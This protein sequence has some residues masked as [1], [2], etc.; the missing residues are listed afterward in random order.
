MGRLAVGENVCT[1]GACRRKC[2]VEEG[3][4]CSGGTYQE[5]DYVRRTDEDQDAT[6]ASAYTHA[7]EMAWA[8]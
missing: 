1:P 2:L 5:R 3:G 6:G 4:R 8:N 7:N